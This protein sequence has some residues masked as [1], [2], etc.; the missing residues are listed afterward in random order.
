MS[1]FKLFIINQIKLYYTKNI[2]IF[3]AIV[4]FPL[5]Y[6]SIIILIFLLFLTISYLFFRKKYCNYKKK[7]NISKNI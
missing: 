7:T 1:L 2:S 6:L 5:F 3:I 4:Y